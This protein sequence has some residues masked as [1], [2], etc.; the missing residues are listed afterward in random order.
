VDVTVAVPGSTDIPAYFA[1][2]TAAAG[3]PRPAVVV[4]HEAFGLNEDIRRIADRFAAAGYHAIAP[5]LF[6][7]GGTM[8]CMVALTRALRA[9]DGLAFE[10]IQAARA[11]ISSRPDCTGEVGVAGFC[12]G[13]AFALLLATR[14]FGA[15][16]VQYGQ[17]PKRLDA[18]L[19]GACP[20]VASYGGRDRFLRGSAG[21]LD[22]ALDRAGIEH[23]VK[24]Y[25]EA[26]H[27]FMGQTAVPW[28][29]APMTGLLT[30]AGYV[31]TAAED[32]WD[33][34]LLMFGESLGPARA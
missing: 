30:H 8:R 28:Y 29:L 20:V 2:A 19:A 5:D 10:E 16:A 18:A 33:R 27:S 15:S 17:L 9:G 6:S 13:G 21:R 12:I 34:I 26:G 23:D 14:G 25:P 22:A 32:A 4:V 3:S 7:H 31:D 11:W 1:P 24:E